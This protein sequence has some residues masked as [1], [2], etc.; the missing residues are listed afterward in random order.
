MVLEL[1][2]GVDYRTAA[3]GPGFRSNKD[4]NN[5]MDT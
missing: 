4:V 5:T 2:Q 3:G 1:W